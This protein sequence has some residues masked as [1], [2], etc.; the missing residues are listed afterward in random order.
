M[1][2]YWKK[3]LDFVFP[4]SCPCCGQ[5]VDWG[6]CAECWSRLRF[7]LEPYCQTC[8][9]PL[10]HPDARLC[11]QCLLNKPAYDRGRS[12]LIYDEASKQLV[13]SLKRLDRLDL[14]PLLAQW[15]V[16]AG[17]SLF[18][19][20]TILIPAPLHPLDLWKRRYNQS[21]LLAR[22]IG[23]RVGCRAEVDLIYRTRRRPSQVALT[24]KQRRKNL[25]RMFALRDPSVIQGRHAIVID[26]VLTTGATVEECARVLARAG[27]VD[28]LT[29]TRTNRPSYGL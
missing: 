9:Q 28:I 7:I 1:A 2:T 29:L 6:L 27:R 19:P 20:E 5:E 23:R 4:P 17:R 16:N 15:M 26:D 3:I 18:T 11:G 22:E 25:R 8:G 14:V 13:I 24:Q 21:A 12:A 10:F